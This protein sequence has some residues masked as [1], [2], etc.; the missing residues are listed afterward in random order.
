M[1]LE[2]WAKKNPILPRLQVFKLAAAASSPKVL[3]K[4]TLHTDILKLR[5]CSFLFATV[6]HVLLGILTYY[7][8]EWT[9]LVFFYIFLFDQNEGH[10]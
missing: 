5:S 9:T 8:K 4:E 7:P 1:I 6:C 10:M 2:L 3:N